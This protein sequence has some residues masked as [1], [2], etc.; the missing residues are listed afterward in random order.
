MSLIIL[1]AGSGN[2]CKNDMQYV[3]RMIDEL[4]AVD[5]GKH[6][7][8][9]KWQLFRQAGDNIKLHHAVFDFA[10][11][12][13]KEKGYE[14]TASVFDKESLDYL[15]RYDIPFV[16]IANNRK[17][18]WLTDEAPRKIC[19]FASYD[20]EYLINHKYEMN[21]KSLCCISK[22]PALPIDYER[23]FGHRLVT[24]IS[25]HTVG[26]DLFNKYQPVVWEKHYKLEDSTGLDAGDFAITPSELKEVL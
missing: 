25:D 6:K 1:D 13:A 21:I 18:D 26:I 12:Y 9:I 7:I 19:V 22:Y 17:L 5:T 23:E 14:T 20:K 8:V 11:E 16:K 2:T 3:A 10:Y 4:K 15:L 24:G